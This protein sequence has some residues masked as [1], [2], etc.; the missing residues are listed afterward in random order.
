MKNFKKLA[1]AM[2]ALLVLVGVLCS[3]ATVTAYAADNHIT[4]IDIEVVI[5][6]DGSAVITQ[7]WTGDFLREQKIICQSAQAILVSPSLRCP[8]KTG[9]IPLWKSG[10]W[11]GASKRRQ[12][13]AALWKRMTAWN[14]ALV[15]RSTVR[16]NIPFLMW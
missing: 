8:M 11:T 5:R 15:L 4:N 13:S 3:G 9:R 2:A 12:A 6:N 16:R 1:A 10:M 7:H 14:C